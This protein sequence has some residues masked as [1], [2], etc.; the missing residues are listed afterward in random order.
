VLAADLTT[1][2]SYR[3]LFVNIDANPVMAMIAGAMET[4]V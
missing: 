2:A 4:L 3:F 1:I